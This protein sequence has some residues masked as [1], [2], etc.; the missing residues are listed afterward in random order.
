VLL[1]L[2]DGSPAGRRHAGDIKSYTKEVIDKLDKLIDIHAIG[3]MDDNVTHYYKSHSVVNSE[4]EL[5]PAI[6]NVLERKL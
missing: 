1:V 3:I 2:S 5:T 6:L 4:S